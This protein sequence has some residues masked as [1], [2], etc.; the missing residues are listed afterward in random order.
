[1]ASNMC[2]DGS[3]RE[4]NLARKLMREDEQEQ[5][6]AYVAMGEIEVDGI[7]WLLQSGGDCNNE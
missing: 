2:R 7:V 6:G 3:E 5:Y 4:T 1:M